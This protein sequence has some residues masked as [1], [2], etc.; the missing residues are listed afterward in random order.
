MCGPSYTPT[1]GSIV[2]IVGIGNMQDVP[3]DQQFPCGEWIG[4]FC[5]QGEAARYWMQLELTF[6]DGIICGSGTDRLGLF[7]VR[8]RYRPDDGTCQGSK[9]YVGGGDIFIR[10][11]N[12]GQGIWGV[13]ELSEKI[14]GGYHIWPAHMNLIDQEAILKTVQ[15]PWVISLLPQLAGGVGAEWLTG[16]EGRAE[17]DR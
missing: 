12:E 10:G 16:T 15:Q 8:G 5:R 1:G 7:V 4:F 9:R 14:R 6:A 2:V 13:W 11:Y 17:Q 3:N